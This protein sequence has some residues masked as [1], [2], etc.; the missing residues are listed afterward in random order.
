MRKGILILLI[1]IMVLAAG[2]GQHSQI[3]DVSDDVYARGIE[4]IDYMDQTPMIGEQEGEDQLNAI[5]ADDAPDTDQL[6][7]DVVYVLWVYH[8]L[9]SVE[10]AAEEINKNFEANGIDTTV[11]KE[12]ESIRA[13]I[14]SAATQE[15]LWDIWNG[16]TDSKW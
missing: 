7:E 12:Y 14:L 11:Q 8:N 5:A 13:N 4:F 2:C 9:K 10:S 6:F 15:D 1:C 16:A 3:E